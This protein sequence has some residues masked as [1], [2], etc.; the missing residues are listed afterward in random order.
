VVPRES[1][2]GRRR[3]AHDPL[4]DRI[5]DEAENEDA[6]ALASA[7]RRH[8]DL[9]SA[10]TAYETTRRAA[11]RLP[12]REAANSARWFEQIDRFAT[13]DPRLF[14]FLL[15]RRRSKLLA[16]LPAPAYSLARAVDEVPPLRLLS[17]RASPWRNRRHVR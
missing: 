13:T 10:L 7:L 3:R 5:R 16:R 1:R 17:N 11:L 14:A 8:D 12:P 2:A 15:H 6:I 9:P 4:H